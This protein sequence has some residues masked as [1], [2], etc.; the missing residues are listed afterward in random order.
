MNSRHL[1]FLA[2]GLGFGLAV[3]P[4]LSA[5]K[6]FNVPKYHNIRIDNCSGKTGPCGQSVAAAFCKDNGFKFA[7]KFSVSETSQKTVYYGSFK[8]CDRRVCYPFDR[9]ACTDTLNVTAGSETDIGEVG[10]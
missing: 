2:A 9:I 10:Q 6:I 8:A 5:D 7:R 1:M 4:A 3:T